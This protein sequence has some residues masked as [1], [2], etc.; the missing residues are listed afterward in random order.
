MGYRLPLDSQPWAAAGDMPW[1]HPPDQTQPFAP[2]PSYQRLR[3][4]NL[5]PEA[6]PAESPSQFGSFGDRS[7]A[8]LRGEATGEGR[9]AAPAALP[10]LRT[11][12]RFESAGWVTRTAISAEPRHG[13]L[14]VFMPPASALEDYLELVAAVEDTALE[15]KLP[16]V[17]EGYEPPRTRACRRCV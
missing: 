14:Y 7:R 6:L 10:D 9:S 16:V 1:V 8:A 2:L 11:P 17:L 3:F 13:R 5:H 15:M 4:P 12:Q